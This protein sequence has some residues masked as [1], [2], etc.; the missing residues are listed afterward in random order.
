MTTTRFRQTNEDYRN[1]FSYF[2]V[3]KDGHITAHELETAMNKCGVYPTKLELR[4]IMNQMD[5]DKNGLI[6]FDEFA[7]MMRI[8]EKAQISHRIQCQK[9]IINLSNEQPEIR[10][11]LLAQFRLFDKDN[12]GFILPEEMK[13][14]I[15]E[16]RLGKNFPESVV[17]QLFLEA[18][19]DGDGKIS[20][21]E[22]VMA[23]V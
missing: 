16:L 14:L 13:K 23:V 22:F 7:S 20:F 2:D 18:D 17:D 4:I 10:Q 5:K 19:A 21:E 9:R 3:N 1:A 8:Q 6:T 15:S 11:E 12:D